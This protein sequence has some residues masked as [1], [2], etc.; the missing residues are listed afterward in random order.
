MTGFLLDSLPS[1]PLLI[2]II[3]ITL[4]IFIAIFG[5]LP[6]AFLTGVTIHFLGFEKGI[7]VSIIGES[8]GALISFLLYRKGLNK[9]HL[10]IKKKSNLLK[11]LQNAS[12]FEAILLIILLRIMPF[13]PSGIVTLTA[14]WSKI[15]LIPFT[16]AS[17]IGK[18]PSLLIEA[19]SINKVLSISSPILEE[20]II[21]IT[22][23]VLIIYIFIKKK[24]KKN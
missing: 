8:L 16:V 14:A 18:I 15:K 12:Q 20:N 2:T 9:L 1:N 17:T 7:L 5:F 6:S 13:I 21:Y 4:N 19:Y 11:K 3:S 10:H 23:I 22:I 24:K